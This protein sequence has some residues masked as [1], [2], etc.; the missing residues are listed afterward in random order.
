[1][2]FLSGLLGILLVGFV[3]L[4]AIEV[5][6]QEL[7]QSQPVDFVNYRGQFTRIV[8]PEEFRQTGLG[9]ARG[10]TGTRFTSANRYTILRAIDPREEKGFDADIFM[11][12]PASDIVDIRGVRALLAGYIEGQYGY[13]AR[14]ASTLS[15]FATYYNAIYRGRMDYFRTQYKNVVTS[16]LV[17]ARAGIALDYRAWPGRTQIVVPLGVFAGNTPEIDLNQF[18]GQD[19]IDTLRQKPDMGVEERKDLLDIKQED[20]NKKQD[21]L[22]KKK[23]ALEEDKKKLEDTTQAVTIKQEELEKKQEDLKNEKDP[24]KQE[25]IREELKKDEKG[26]EQLKEELKKEESAVKEKETVIEKAEETLEKKKEE[27]KKEE[28][29]LKKDETKVLED[30]LPQPVKEELKKKEDELEKKTEALEK[31]KTEL[32]TKAEELKQMEE[33]LKKGELDRNIYDG[34]LYYL[35]VIEPLDDGHY[36]NEMVLI[37][38]ISRKVVLS[39]PYKNICGHRYDIFSEGAVVIGY[40][41]KHSSG[42]FLV[43]LDPKTLELTAKG[44]DHVYWKSFIEVKQDSIYTII[45]DNGYYLGKFDNKLSPVARSKEKIDRDSFISFFGQYVYVNS[46]DRTIF[47]FDVTDLKLIDTIKP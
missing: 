45:Q 29:Q 23:E 19:V 41:G 4:F 43:L 20:L 46:P 33:E 42:H 44:K 13:N 28:E 21:D 47:V 18:T 10:A 37:N 26:L 32:D 6:E 27:V 22:D 11:L 35:K 24:V 36:K 25:Q 12:E 17:P 5:A 39:S 3:P 8:S 1:M 7:L 40:D 16:Q 34:G 15:L 38:P 30:K 14:N 31:Q 2:R 9:I